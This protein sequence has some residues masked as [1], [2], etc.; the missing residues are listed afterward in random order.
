[1][2]LDKLK[3]AA[4]KIKDAIL[5][6]S[7][8]TSDDTVDRSRLHFAAAL[9]TAIAAPGI[10]FAAPSQGDK[11][12]L[13]AIFGN[14]VED[15]NTFRT[16]L[17]GIDD[18]EV[19]EIMGRLGEVITL[20][21]EP[22]GSQVIDFH[23][24]ETFEAWEESGRLYSR[25]FGKA[26]AELFLQ[27]PSVKSVVTTV[28]FKDFMKASSEK[29][30]PV[31]EVMEAVFE[32]AGPEHE[33]KVKN[34]MANIYASIS[35][36]HA[37]RCA[38]AKRDGESAVFNDSASESERYSLKLLNTPS[39]DLYV[40]DSMKGVAERSR[41]ALG[42]MQGNR[43]FLDDLIMRDQPKQA[44]MIKERYG[45][46]LKNHPLMK[47]PLRQRL[48]LGHVMHLVRYEL[49]RD[50]E[51]EFHCT[52]GLEKFYA[53]VKDD[54][55]KFARESGQG[56]M[57]KS[58]IIT[59]DIKGHCYGGKD[60]AILFIEGN[61]KTPEYVGGDFIALGKN[62]AVHFDLMGGRGR[63]F[64]SATPFNMMG[65]SMEDRMEK[66]MKIGTPDH[67]YVVPNANVR[68]VHKIVKGYGYNIG[69]KL[70]G[71]MIPVLA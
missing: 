8:E 4:G 55:Q 44:D 14:T 45:N 2:K 27:A 64:V 58:D 37:K 36:S 30:V 1:M 12:R 52:A 53:Q 10:A 5:P 49:L 59:C 62:D 24:T 63:S 3:S 22:D 40:S 46:E 32:L 57:S 15:A 50:I 6:S 9:T 25:E 28:H 65:R 69:E 17:E 11:N 68:E 71:K 41:I 18:N 29:V 67:I 39:T 70:K 7:V 42:L 23:T 20:N 61:T 21:E 26:L 16:R 56:M 60:F 19:T 43:Q 51:E 35:K 31:L 66:N 47:A 38:F 48:N 33:K 34:V 54:E 13:N